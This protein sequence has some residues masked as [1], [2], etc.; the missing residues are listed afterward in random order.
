MNAMAF[1]QPAHIIEQIGLHDGMEVADFGSGAGYY[2]TAA[3]D[4]VGE[5]GR[6]YAIDIQRELLTKAK[7]LDTK[8]RDQIEYVSGDLEEPGGSGLKEAIVDVVII[9]NVLFQLEHKEVAIEEAKRVL[10]PKGKLVLIDWLE[11]FGG[12]GPPAEWIIAQE[13]AR[14]LCER[15]GFVHQRDIDAGDHHYGMVF[16]KT[17]A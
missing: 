17:G 13:E 15:A 4:K 7:G 1:A 6:V 5:D 16:Q 9:S 2:A 8:R 3:A 14:A 11:S 10:R 12:L